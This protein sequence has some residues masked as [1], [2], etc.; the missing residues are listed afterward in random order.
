VPA[1]GALGRVVGVG[2]DVAE[3]AREIAMSRGAEAASREVDAVSR[4]GHGYC[5]GGCSSN[6]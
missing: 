5:G 2:S 1:G 4:D 6:Q 3:T